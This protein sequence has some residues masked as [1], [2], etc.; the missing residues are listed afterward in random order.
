MQM[1]SIVLASAVLA[2]LSLGRADAAPGSVDVAMETTLGTIVVRLDTAHAPR[3]AA[4]FLR[5]VDGGRFNGASFYR[6]VTRATSPGAPFEVIQ[7]G[8]DPHAEDASTQPIALEPTSA[9][10]LHNDDGAIAMAR[11]SDPNSA[12]TEFFIDLGN[13][14]YLDATGPLAPGYAAFGRVVRGMDI[15]RRIHRGRTEGDRLAPAVRITRMHRV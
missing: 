12:T 7:G 1:R 8:L 15:V 11:T 9:T 14:R 13:A 6:N 3:T 4:N 2:A 5:Y 10:G